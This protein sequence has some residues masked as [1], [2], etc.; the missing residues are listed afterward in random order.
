VP[1][2][3]RRAVTSA[4]ASASISTEPASF[5]EFFKPNFFLF[6]F[7][8]YFN[9]GIFFDLFVKLF[10]HNPFQSLLRCFL[11]LSGRFS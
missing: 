7:L 2:W 9:G 11:F 1:S 6:S 5:G 3:R 10:A 8:S 4:A